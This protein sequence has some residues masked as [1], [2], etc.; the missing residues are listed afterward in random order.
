MSTVTDWYSTSFYY[1]KDTD[2]NS[3]SINFL[4]LLSLLF[5]LVQWTNRYERLVWRPI[6]VDALAIRIL[7]GCHSVELFHSPRS[8]VFDRHHLRELFLRGH[9]NVEHGTFIS[10]SLLRLFCQDNGHECHDEVD[11]LLV[12]R[13]IQFWV[14]A[15]NSVWGRSLYKPPKVSDYV[16]IQP[17]GWQFAHEFILDFRSS[18]CHSDFSIHLASK[19]G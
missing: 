1:I 10:I 8:W 2:G 3:V 5:V 16:H 11:N 19:I 9:H 18:H 14:S 17:S 4:L 13:T 12:I 6:R 7:L 15:D